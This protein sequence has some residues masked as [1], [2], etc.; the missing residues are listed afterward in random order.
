MPFKNR[1]LFANTISK[2][3]IEDMKNRK[4]EF[5]NAG[6]EEIQNAVEFLRVIDTRELKANSRM[7]QFSFGNSIV[8]RFETT[9]INYD[10]YPRNGLGTSRAYGPR[11]YDVLGAVNML[12]RFRAK[13]TISESVGTPRPV[14]FKK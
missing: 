8:W 1:R 4:S 10:I 2:D 5:E 9:G 12:K 3:V 11:K 6:T 14:K 7:R 13:V